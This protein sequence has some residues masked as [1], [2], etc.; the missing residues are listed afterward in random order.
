M[1]ITIKKKLFLKQMISLSLV[2]KLT[3]FHM[4]SPMFST[5]VIFKENNYFI[6]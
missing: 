1:L 5:K 4:L 2:S 3:Q 6:L